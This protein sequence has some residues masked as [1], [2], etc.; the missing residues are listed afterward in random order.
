MTLAKKTID[1]INLYMYK[2]LKGNSL[3]SACLKSNY[4]KDSDFEVFV[5]RPEDTVINNTDLCLLDEHHISTSE[6]PVLLVNNT[7]IPYDE[8]FDYI[9]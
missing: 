2:D 6:L 7:F 5:I 4:I 1:V 3:L 9:K 8:A